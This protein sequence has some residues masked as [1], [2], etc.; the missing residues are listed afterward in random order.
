MGEPRP[1]PTPREKRPEPRRQGMVNPDMEQPEVPGPALG[2]QASS[3]VQVNVEEDMPTNGGSQPVNESATDR[4][5][6]Y[7][8]RTIAMVIV[9]IVV[10]VL[11]ALPVVWGLVELVALAGVVGPL[12]WAWAALLIVLLIGAVLI[13]FHIAQSGL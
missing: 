11:L 4:Y 10:A 5:G 2:G 6:L 3:V 13:G 12:I 7:Y 9:A 8:P 1:D